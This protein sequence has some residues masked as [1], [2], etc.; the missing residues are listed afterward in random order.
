M[1]RDPSVPGLSYFDAVLG[2]PQEDKY[3]KTTAPS[4]V[5]KTLAPRLFPD[6]GSL[7]FCLVAYFVWLLSNTPSV[8]LMSSVTRPLRPS[9]GEVLFPFSQVFPNPCR[10]KK[11]F[12]LSSACVAPRGV[13]DSVHHDLISTLFLPPLF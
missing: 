12:F 4:P 8:L 11:H 7:K 5:E 6:R 1:F 3:N 10:M 9:V 2:K 13:F